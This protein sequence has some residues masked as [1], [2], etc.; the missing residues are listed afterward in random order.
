MELPPGAASCRGGARLPVP[1]LVSP[2]SNQIRATV[3]RDGQLAS[4]E[5]VGATLLANACGPCI[6]Q[7]QREGVARDEP[8]SIL[9]SFNRNFRGRND[10]NPGTFA[11]IASPEVVMQ[12]GVRVNATGNT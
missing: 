6:G 7:W 4:F 12:T 2:G 3:E 10:G 1:L 11:F 5:A 9:T 8:N